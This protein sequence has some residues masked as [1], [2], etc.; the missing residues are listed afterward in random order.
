MA[1]TREA[2]EEE[3]GTRGEPNVLFSRA[4]DLPI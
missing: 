4:L 1:R 3:E 2:G